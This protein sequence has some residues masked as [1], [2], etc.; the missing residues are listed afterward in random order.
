MCHPA[1]VMN[2]HPICSCTVL[3]L[4]AQVPPLR[5]RPADI[6]DLERYFM[7]VLSKQRG[8]RLTLTGE[9]ERQ[10]VAYTF[11]NN[12]VVRCTRFVCIGLHSEQSWSASVAGEKSSIQQLS[13]W[14]SPLL[15]APASPPLFWTAA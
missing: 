9:A 2:S 3:L 7:R 14:T 8:V 6:I 1:D 5:V 15:E 10:L 13:G 12:I 11:P 4:L